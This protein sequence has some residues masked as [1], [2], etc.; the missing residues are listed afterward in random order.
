[1]TIVSPL[2]NN[3]LFARAHKRIDSERLYLPFGASYQPNSTVELDINKK[4]PQRIVI[5]KE[6]ETK[7]KRGHYHYPNWCLDVSLILNVC[8]VCVGVGV[9]GHNDSLTPSDSV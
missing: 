7:R 4:Q 5:I 8:V 1:M 9:D 3:L 6:K 2:P